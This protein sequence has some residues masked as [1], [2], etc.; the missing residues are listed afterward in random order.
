MKAFDPN[1]GR[2]FTSFLYN[3]IDWE[4]KRE[5]QK[6][7]R[8][9]R[10][11]SI[12]LDYPVQDFKTLNEDQKIQ[13]KDALSKIENKYELVIKQRFFDRMT[14]QEIASK[15]NYSRETARRYINIGL[16]KLKECLPR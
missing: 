15:N 2:K 10:K 4:C 5:I 6:M 1:G 12:S 11:S 14:M 7:N 3:R 13:I 8:R 16:E 9:K